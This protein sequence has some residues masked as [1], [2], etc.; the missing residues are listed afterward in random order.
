MD[1][2]EAVKIA[3]EKAIK[4]GATQAEAYATKS[5][6]ISIQASNDRIGGVKSR[7]ALNEVVEGLSIRVAVNKS[8]AYAHT[9]ILSREEIEETIKRAL[10]IA[11]IREPDPDFKTLPQPKTPTKVEGIFDPKI[12]TPPI[13]ESFEKIRKTLSEGMDTDKN[14]NTIGASYNFTYMERAICNSLGI[15]VNYKESMASTGISILGERDGI[16]SFGYESEANREINKLSI[17][18]CLEKAV[19]RTKIGF[20]VAKIESGEKT[21]IFDPDALESLMEFAFIRAIDA[22]NVQEGKSYLTGKLGT[23]ISSE[24]LT[25]IDD[26]TLKGGLRTTP[27]D[28][29]GVPSQKT[30]IIENGILKSYIYDSYTAHKENRESTGNAFRQFRTP[31]TIAPRNQIIKGE[32]V[33]LEELIREVNEGII[34]Q[35]VMGAHSTNIATGAF[36]ITANP[37]YIIKK[38]EIIGQVK[39]CMIAG[40]FKELL[41]KYTEQGDDIKQRGSLIAPSIKF[42]KVRITT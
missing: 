14:F 18:K 15:E 22:Y 30:I 39:G 36:S 23:K 6:R 9:T 29:E 37:S 19:E 2:I 40:T 5:N 38:G 21:V 35:G 41:E 10:K 24:K 33:K 7:G 17:E 27:T 11:K 32:E 25:I 16:R 1:L 26:G 42:E 12:I 20:K 31:I 3:V 13:E 8:L 34:I 4:Y 28:V